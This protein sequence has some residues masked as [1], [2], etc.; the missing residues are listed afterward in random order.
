VVAVLL[1]KQV[2]AQRL[3]LVGYWRGHRGHGQFSLVSV[4]CT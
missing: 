1:L 3:A 2:V 4:L